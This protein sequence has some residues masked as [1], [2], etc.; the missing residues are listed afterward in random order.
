MILE[1]DTSSREHIIIR[2]CMKD[3]VL[4]EKKFEAK[5]SQAEKL[6]PEIDQ[7]LRKEKKTAKDLKKIKVA[8]K[9]ESFTA[10]RVGVVVA[11]TLAYGLDIP[12]E[13]LNSDLGTR[14]VDGINMVFPEY[15]KEPNI[16]IGKKKI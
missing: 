13:T 6:L 15:D 3:E 7:L 11:N 9:G 5:F 8:N 12:I 16:T 14:E 1:I 2:L 4:A 10:L